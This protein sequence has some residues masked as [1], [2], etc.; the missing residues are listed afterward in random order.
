MERKNLS[1]LPKQDQKKKKEFLYYYDYSPNT[2]MHFIKFFL[3]APFS[4]RWVTENRVIRRDWMGKKSSIE[5]DGFQSS[6][7]EDGLK[8][9]M[10]TMS[11]WSC[12]KSSSI[13]RRQWKKD[14]PKP[15]SMIQRW[16]STLSSQ[17]QMLHHFKNR[18]ESL[19]SLLR[20]L[21]NSLCLVLYF[22]GSSWWH[23]LW[24]LFFLAIFCSFLAIFRYW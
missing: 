4:S 7:V 10:S 15:T 24:L 9:I 16:I 14:S 1:V 12:C 19:I 20:S 3:S 13:Q 2:L 17:N 6:F 23:V 5:E 11:V 22:D 8:Y 18:K 21:K